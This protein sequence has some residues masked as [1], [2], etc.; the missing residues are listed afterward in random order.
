MSSP[1]AA[2]PAGSVGRVQEPTPTS[3]APGQPFTPGLELAA[4]F[5]REVVSPLLADVP[6]ASALLGWGSDVLGYDTPRSTDH[7]W[8]PRLQVF[9]AAGDVERAAALVEAGLPQRYRGR[10]VRFGWDGMRPRSQVEVT[11]W[12]GWLERQIGFADPQAMS[13]RDWLLVPQQR[14]LEVVA[15]AVFADPGGEVARARAA[16]AWFPDDVHRWLLACQ[17]RRLAQEE[18]FV[19]RTAEVGD[20]LGSAVVAARLVREAMRLALLLAGRYAPYFKWLGTAFGRLEH[21]DGLDGHLRRAVRA[22]DAGGREEALCAAYE[23]LARR[24]NATS[25]AEELDPRVRGF[26]E[27]PARVLDADRFAAA[28]REA[29]TEPALRALPLLGSVDQVA[30]STDLFGSPAACLR[31]RALYRD[32]ADERARD[33]VGVEAAVEG[34]GP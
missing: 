12:P 33:G 21:A 2:A 9:V 23:A 24:Q 17:W 19:Q 7:G 10:E 14:L 18:P 28:C 26:H 11:T 6:H 3:R 1:A 4:G 25:L 15:G 32:G 20:E 8:G 27:R 22:V 30:D 29:V 31:L 34:V 13:W 16:L 5:A